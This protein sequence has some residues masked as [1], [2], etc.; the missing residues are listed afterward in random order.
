[1]AGMTLKSAKAPKAPDQG[2]IGG[3]TAAPSRKS[4]SVPVQTNPKKAKKA[5]NK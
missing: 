1:M 4:L 5:R 3:G 2:G